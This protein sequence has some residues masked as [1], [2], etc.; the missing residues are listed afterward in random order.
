L[1]VSGIE[2]MTGNMPALLSLAAVARCPSHQMFS[3]LVVET[4]C[5]MGPLIRKMAA[6]FICRQI[7]FRAILLGRKLEDS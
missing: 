5:N 6:L 2:R 4:S 1:P 7:S 3:T